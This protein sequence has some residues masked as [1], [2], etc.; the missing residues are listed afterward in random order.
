[1][2][3]ENDRLVKAPSSSRAVAEMSAS[4]A[5]QSHFLRNASLHF[6]KVTCND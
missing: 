3:H 4:Q 1:M 6:N 2:A 5:R